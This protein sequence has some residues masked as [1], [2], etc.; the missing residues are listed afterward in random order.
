MKE[1]DLII[2][3]DCIGESDMYNCHEVGKLVRCKDCIHLH[4]HDCPIDW[5]ITDDDYC[6]FGERKDSGEND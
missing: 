6:S 3:Y 4:D 5:G 2:H 1:F